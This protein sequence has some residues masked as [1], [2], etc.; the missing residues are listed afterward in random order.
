MKTTL[1]LPDDLLREVKIRAAQQNRRMKDVIAEALR[2]SLAAP[3]AAP[4]VPLSPVAALRQR[5]VSHA[6]GSISNPGGM[7]DPSFFDT[8]EALRDHSRSEPMRDLFRPA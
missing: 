7:D 4:S 1:E 3:A 2:S 6:D 8:L 5:L